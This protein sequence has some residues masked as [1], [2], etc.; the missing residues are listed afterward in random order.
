M[1]ESGSSDRNKSRTTEGTTAVGIRSAAIGRVIQ[2]VGIGLLLGAAVAFGL[3]ACDLALPVGLEPGAFYVTVTPPILPAPRLPTVLPVVSIQSTPMLPTRV[4]TEPPPSPTPT[5]T[6][7]EAPIIPTLVPCVAPPGWPKEMVYICSDLFI[8]GSDQGRPNE[9]PVHVVKL[10]SFGIDRLEVTWGWYQACVGAQACDVVPRPRQ[11]WEADDFPV[12]S[13]T[14]HAAAKFCVWAGKRLPT[15]AEWEAAAHGSTPKPSSWP[16]G[17]KWN[18]TLANTQESD[19]GRPTAVG[20]HPGDKSPYGILDMAGNVAE[21]VNDIY[22][23]D[24]TRL[25]APLDPVFATPLPSQQTRVVRGGSFLL[26]ANAARTT[27]RADWHPISIRDDLGFRCA[28]S[29]G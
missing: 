26:D 4:P 23:P 18:P 21:W 5:S 20:T 3:V 1:G 8:I 14:W 29:G 11:P 9:K 28:K 16:W 12:T 25:S 15:E 13:V 27:A 19:V 7:T 17:D 6:A 10:D 2:G 22:L 24:Y